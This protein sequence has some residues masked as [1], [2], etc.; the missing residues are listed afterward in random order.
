MKITDFIFKYE[1]ARWPIARV[2]I[3][4]V[5]IFS[6]SQNQ[7]YVVLTELDENPGSSVTNTLEEILRQLLTAQKIPS[8][9]GVID[10]SP[11]ALGLREDF[12]LVSTSEKGDI[13][14]QT[15][16][17]SAVQRLTE[18]ASAC[19]KQRNAVCALL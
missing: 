11:S 6:N 13:C 1:T 18:C 14:R 17:H 10:H 19:R 2:G 4:R 12:S 3:F 7:I 5:R 8:T 16:S 9:A 15:L